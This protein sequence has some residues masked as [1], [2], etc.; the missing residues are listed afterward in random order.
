MNS[1]AKRWRTLEKNKE[2]PSRFSTRGTDRGEKWFESN[3]IYKE[4]CRRS[5]KRYQSFYFREFG[6][7]S[8]KMNSVDTVVETYR[9]ENFLSFAGSAL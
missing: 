4:F 6:G 1:H 7:H 3:R 8:T 9:N 2:N 5:R